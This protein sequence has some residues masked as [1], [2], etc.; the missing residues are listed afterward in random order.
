M[1]KQ[2]AIFSAILAVFLAFFFL[3]LVMPPAEALA[4]D[5]LAGAFNEALLMAHDYAHEHV[6]LCLIPAFFIAG[7][8]GNFISAGSVMRYLGA[9]ARRVTAYAVASVSGSVLAVCS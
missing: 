6:L 3:N 8:I 7:A 9:G 2:I 5:G 4:T 1:N